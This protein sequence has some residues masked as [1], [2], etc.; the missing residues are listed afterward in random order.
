MKII[1]RVL[2]AWVAITVASIV[3]VAAVKR[4]APSFGKPDDDVFS[5]V[6]AM[7]GQEFTSTAKNFTT[8]SA[9]ALMG[10]IEIDLT[11]AT[12]DSEAILRLRAVMGGIEVVVPAAWRVEVASRTF[13]GGVENDT[14]P[15]ATELL[16]DEAPQLHVYATATMGGIEI[17][18]P[19]DA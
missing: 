13:L 2:L 1:K 12:L 18:T 15:D 19:E 4:A 10:G 5:I 9:L 7:D 3:A 6:A 17:S 16:S 11:G 14:D 8:G